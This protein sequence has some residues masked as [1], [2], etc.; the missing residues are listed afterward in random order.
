MGDAIPQ[1]LINQIEDLGHCREILQQQSIVIYGLAEEVKNL[2][3]EIQEMLADLGT[4][5]EDT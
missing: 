5:Q 3:V 4:G 1:S 2:R